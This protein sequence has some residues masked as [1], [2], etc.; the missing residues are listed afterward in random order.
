MTAYHE[1]QRLFSSCSRSAASSH[2]WRC[3]CRLQLAQVR[4]HGAV[5]PEKVGAGAKLTRRAITKDG[6]VAAAE[7][8]HE[9]RPASLEGLR[10]LMDVYKE[11]EDTEKERAVRDAHDALVGKH[12]RFSNKDE[13]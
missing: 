8:A 7:A 9:A 12:K 2:R 1:W 6:C 4:C 13:L 11:T 3:R 10:L 5:P